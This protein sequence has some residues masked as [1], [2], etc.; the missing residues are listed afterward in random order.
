MRTNT[1]FITILSL[2]FI[3]LSLRSGSRQK[4][5]RIFLFY[6]SHARFSIKLYLRLIQDRFQCVVNLM[7]ELLRGDFAFLQLRLA[8][9]KAPQSAETSGLVRAIFK[10]VQQWPNIVCIQASG[11]IIFDI[12]RNSL[13]K[14]GAPCVVIFLFYFGHVLGYSVHCYV[15]FLGCIVLSVFCLL[16]KVD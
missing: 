11:S 14:Q 13:D 10:Y 6:W 12:S 16:E 4:G 15:A 9:K 5:G 3:V 1:L 8:T 2:L 7:E